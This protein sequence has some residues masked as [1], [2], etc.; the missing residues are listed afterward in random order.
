MVLSA[1]S[2]RLEGERAW[3]EA[4]NTPLVKVLELFE[5]RGAE[6]LIDPSLELGRVSGEWENT[7]VDRLIAQLAQPHNY[8]LEWKQ[9]SGPLGEF[10]QV[11]S[12]R[13]FSDGKASAARPL[14]TQRKVL[15]VVEGKNGVKHIR[16]EIMVGFGE[17]STQA[18]LKALLG[19]LGGTVIEVIDPP[20]IYR[21]KLND[22]LSVEEALKIA[23]AHEG[24][25]EAEPNLALPRLADM[26]PSGIGALEGVNLNL[27]PGES[28]VAVLDS[29][30]DPKY[31]DNSL[32]RGSY[33]ALNPNEEMS[34]PSGHGTLVALIASGAITPLGAEPAESGVPVLAIRVFDENG[35]TSADIIM[36]AIDYAVYSGVD[37]INMSFG[38]YEDIGFL[39]HA[40][41]YAAEKGIAL[42]AATGN[43]G[44]DSPVFPAANP[45]VFGVGASNPDGTRADFSNYGDSVFTYEP[46]FV[47]FNG[48]THRGSSFG[49]PFYARKIAQYGLK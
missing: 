10:L 24:V 14:S 8:L 6:V 23:L 2:L 31:A 32:I 27:R 18:D 48:K 3:V 13:I 9:A 47:H 20:G 38:S 46:G 1:A 5:Q 37:V 36:R 22:G 21:I 40:L 15:D 44:V 35:Y 28:A 17:G 30:L 12:I 26:A 33:N 19:K 39:N 34:D 42:V 49:A 45:L 29:G 7:K 11:A 43:D 16:G 25:K 4:E 41:G